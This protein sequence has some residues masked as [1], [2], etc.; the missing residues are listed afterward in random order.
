MELTLRSGVVRATGR[1][2]RTTAWVAVWLVAG[3]FV[4]GIA[5]AEPPVTVR[6]VED[7]L[8][9]APAP[10]EPD[11]EGPREQR[12]DEV[13]REGEDPLVAAPAPGD[14]HSV[15]G[16]RTMTGYLRILV[17]RVLGPF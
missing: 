4:T 3:L 8:R 11:F 12:P 16:V 2:R 10:N 15:G 9:A 7:P 5:L 6:D 13:T 14:P 1:R 17:Q